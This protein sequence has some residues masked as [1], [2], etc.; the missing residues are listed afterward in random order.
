LEKKTLVCHLLS[1]DGRYTRSVTSRAFP[2]LVVADVS[3]FLALL[4]QVDENGIVRQF[5]EWVRQQAW[6]KPGPPP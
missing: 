4:G 2:N 1:S 3:G 5:R 6:S